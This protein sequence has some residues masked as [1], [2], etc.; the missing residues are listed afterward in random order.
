MQRQASSPSRPQPPTQ[1]PKEDATPRGAVRGGPTSGPQ[2]EGTKPPAPVR[3]RMDGAPG[4]RGPAGGQ[5]KGLVPDRSGV[6]PVGH[7][8]P[9]VI[10]G[11]RRVSQQR[12]AS[13]QRSI[14]SS[15]VDLEESLALHNWDGFGVDEDDVLGSR[16]FRLETI[17]DGSESPDRSIGIEPQQQ[18]Q[19]ANHNGIDTGMPKLAAIRTHLPPDKQHLLATGNPLLDGFASPHVAGVLAAHGTVAASPPIKRNIHFSSN[20][21]SQ[22][23]PST[24]VVAANIIRPSVDGDVDVL[25][26]DVTGSLSGAPPAA[27]NGLHYY[28]HVSGQLPTYGSGRYGSGTTPIDVLLDDDL[29]LAGAGG[30]HVPRVGWGPLMNDVAL[31]AHAVSIAFGRDAWVHLEAMKY[32]ICLAVGHCMCRTGGS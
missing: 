18:P 27:Q 28:G 12:R 10:N 16:H 32:S 15:S 25:Q 2:R 22:Y 1:Q 31:L 23:I 19:A 30:P 6:P 3:R 4:E 8:P 13:H 5:A 11:G 9:P 29:L 21:N 14:A 17:Q 24:S 20:S 7:S 26:G